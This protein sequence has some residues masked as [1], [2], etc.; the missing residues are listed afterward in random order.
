MF[1]ILSSFKAS[2]VI[3][4]IVSGIN[5][6]LIDQRSMPSRYLLSKIKKSSKNY[7]YGELLLSINISMID[8]M[9]IEYHF[10]EKYPK[11]L[12]NLIKKLER[13]SFSL[14]IKKLSNDMGLIFAKKPMD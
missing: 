13:I 6:N 4:P 2:H 9:I 12:T 8:K 14:D 7:N 1:L 11:L 5:R 3:A 10:A